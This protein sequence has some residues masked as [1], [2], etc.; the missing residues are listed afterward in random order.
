[1]EDSSINHS[2]MEK[3]VSASPAEESGWTSYFEDFSDHN[4]EDHSLCCGTFDSSSMVSDAASFPPWK[5]SNVVAGSS[6]NGGLPR[7]LTFKKTRAKEIS[8]DDSLEDT[9]SSP[10]NSPKVSDMIRPTDN[11]RKT[12]DQYFNSSLGNKEGSGLEQYAEGL[13]T[14][15][16]CDIIFG[17]GKNDVVD[18]KKRGLCLVPLSMLVNYL[19]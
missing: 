12:N 19:G 1:M 18:L 5:S 11:H 17:G 14:S 15:E 16:R 9:A 10:V 8:L 6:I 3:A 7:K 4:E 13:E 2:S